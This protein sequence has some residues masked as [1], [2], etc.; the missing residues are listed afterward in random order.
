MSKL[1]R[2]IIWSGITAILFFIILIFFYNTSALFPILGIIV[3]LGLLKDSIDFYLMANGQHSLGGH[4]V[5][6]LP[7]MIATA[8]VSAVMLADTMDLN[9]A[10]VLIAAIVDSAIDFYQDQKCC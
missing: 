10:A 8:A 6:H 7:I 1:S 3:I 4:Y 2:Y 5:E 9:W